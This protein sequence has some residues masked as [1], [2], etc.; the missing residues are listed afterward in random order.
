MAEL[1]AEPAM[2]ERGEVI[3]TLVG[4][5]ITQLRERPQQRAATLATIDELGVYTDAAGFLADRFDAEI[6]VVREADGD[7][8]R[9]VPFRPELTLAVDQEE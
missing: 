2:R 4:E 9:P 6:E 1:M 8:V 5:L 7:A 3:N